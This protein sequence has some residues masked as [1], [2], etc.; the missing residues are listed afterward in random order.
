MYAE[1]S[2]PDPHHPLTHHRNSPEWIEKVTK[3][4]CLH[5]ELF[6]YFLK[7]LHCTNDGEGTL[8]DRS[9]I[10]YGSGLSDG[11][12]HTHENLPVLLAGHGNGSLK[13]G[14]HIVYKQGTPMTNLYLGL[15]DRMGVKPDTLGDSTGRLEHLTEL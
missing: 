4:N 9:M 13:P 10:V 14:R 11:N 2:V 7:R 6:S 5:T 15:L 3:I 12:R 8:L 1:I